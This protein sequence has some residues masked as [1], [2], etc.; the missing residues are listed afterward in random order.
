MCSN[1]TI[2]CTL[3]HTY[4]SSVRGGVRRECPLEWLSVSGRAVFALHCGGTLTSRALPCVNRALLCPLS[5]SAPP[6]KEDA[7]SQPAS[8]VSLP[9]SQRSRERTYPRL[10]SSLSPSLKCM[11]T[12]DYSLSL[13][14]SLCLSLFLSL[15][16]SR[17]L[18]FPPSLSLFPS[19]S[20]V[21]SDA[22]THTHKQSLCLSLCL[23]HPSILVTRTTSV[24]FASVRTN[25]AM[26]AGENGQGAGAPENELLRE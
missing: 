7:A 23:F 1:Q 20:L 21:L 12:A 8:Q 9:E 11:G 22:H 15:L 6:Y 10:H 5:L 17:P 18:S 26:V 24:A 16:L 4:A 13:S 14:R 3:A 25:A 2:A 19:L